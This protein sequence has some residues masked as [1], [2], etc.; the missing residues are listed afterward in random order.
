VRDERQALVRIAA[1]GD[2]V[3]VDPARRLPGRGGYL[4]PHGVCLERFIGSRVKEFRSLKRKINR[5]ERLRL[6]SSI[7]QFEQPV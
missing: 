1:V 4:H 3:E 6:T 2:R 7:N 5:D